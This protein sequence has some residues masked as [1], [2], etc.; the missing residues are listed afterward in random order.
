MGVPSPMNLDDY[1]DE[2]E[3]V[4]PGELDSDFCSDCREHAQFYRDATGELYSHCCDAPPLPV[5]VERD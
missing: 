4:D 5:D 3:L 2:E 1:E